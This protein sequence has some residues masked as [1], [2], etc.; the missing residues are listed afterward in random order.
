MHHIFSCHGFSF[1]SASRRPTVSPDSVSC[2]VRRTISSASRSIVHRAR[3]T[4][5]REHATATKTASSLAPSLRGAPGRGDSLSATAK[6]SSTKR[7]LVL[8]TVDVP[9]PTVRAISSSVDWASAARRICARLIWR[10]A[11]WPP[12]RSVCSCCRSSAVSVTRSRM[13]I[14]ILDHSPDPVSSHRSHRFTAKQGQYLAFIHT[15]TLLHRESPAEADFQ[16]FF[17]VTPPAIHDMIVALERRG[18]ISRVPRRSEEHT[19]E[20]QSPDHL[21]CRL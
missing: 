18:L 16:R 2:A 15:Y 6:P 20:L 12:L 1:I 8:Y 11:P 19:S 13:F 4:G 21:V 14:D 3:P 5:G 10:T 9:T 17:Q 7:C